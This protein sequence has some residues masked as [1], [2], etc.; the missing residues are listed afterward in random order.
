MS[1]EGLMEAFGW[2]AA[3]AARI[4]EAKMK[5][6]A[7]RWLRGQRSLGVKY[8][9]WPAVR[10]AMLDRF[11]ALTSEVAAT[12]AIHD[13]KQGQHESVDEF[14]DRVVLAL[15][16]KNHR[17]TNATRATQEWKDQVKIDLYTFFGAGLRKVI[18]DAKVSSPSPPLNAQDL[19]KAARYVETSTKAQERAQMMAINQQWQFSPSRGRGATR[20]S[21]RGGSSFSSPSSNQPRAPGAPPASYICFQCQR[22]GHYRANCPT[23]QNQGGGRNRRRN[24]GRGQST[25]VSTTNMIPAGYEDED[26]WDA[27]ETTVGQALAAQFPEGPKIE[28]IASSQAGN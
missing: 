9:D 4:A 10:T 19:L 25:V 2:E 1:F 3:K 5:G 12:H 20:G 24:R 18:R 14:F 13:L 16:Q 7:A 6:K 26:W 27:P 28:S 21:G 15:D 17:V 22:P 23:L 11:K 8:E